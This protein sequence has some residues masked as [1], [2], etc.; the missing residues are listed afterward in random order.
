[1][2]RKERHNARILAMQGIYQ[3][4]LT[5]H[6]PAYIELQIRDDNTIGKYD[7]AYFSKILRGALDEKEKL[8]DLLAPV[9]DRKV[10]E[11][12]PVELAIL[13]LAVYELI[14][15]SDIPYKVII[16]EAL[17]I[18]KRYGSHDGYKYINGVLDK[19]ARE[20]RAGEVSGK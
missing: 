8:D 20:H 7:S 18:A 19:M 17:E 2:Q 4:Q 14:H 11:L 9:L 5:E 10:D 16:N 15:C 3:W 13:R 12:N 1:M 6:D